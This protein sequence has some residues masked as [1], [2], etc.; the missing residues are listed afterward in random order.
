MSTRQM[1]ILFIFSI[2][3]ICC[4]TNPE[5]NNSICTY[6]DVKLDT[7]GTILEKSDIIGTWTLRCFVD[8][9]DCS[10]KNEPEGFPTPAVVISFQDS[11]KV[12]G[13]T[14]PEFTGNYTL[15]NNN[16]KISPLLRPELPEPKPEWANM[17]YKA[18]L[19]ADYAFIEKSKL[20]I[21]FNQSSHVMV[22]TKK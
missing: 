2:T 10:V 15:S 3:C 8:I 21:F 19:T 11:G 9:S 6:E 14:G 13:H 16:I 12:S 7:T 22:F 1:L 4:S 18:A 20:F 17:F 5:D